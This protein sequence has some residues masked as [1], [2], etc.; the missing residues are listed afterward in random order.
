[1]QIEAFNRLNQTD[2]VQN[3]TMEELKLELSKS[4]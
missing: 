3:K 2:Q 4:V 1:M